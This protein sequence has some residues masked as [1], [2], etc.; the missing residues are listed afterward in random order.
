MLGNST[1]QDELS[2][3]RDKKLQSVQAFS[4]NHFLND[5]KRSK[6][7]NH[8]AMK[9]KKFNVM[10]LNP[11]YETTKITPRELLLPY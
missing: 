1:S 10:Q 3:N 6:K 2:P 11:A 8:Y 7:M 5:A 9:A 4:S